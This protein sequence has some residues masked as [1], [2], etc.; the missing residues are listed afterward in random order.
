MFK[1]EKKDSFNKKKKKRPKAKYEDELTQI[2]K[3][4]GRGLSFL[5]DS[6]M[7]VFRCLSLYYFF[8][9]LRELF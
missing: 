2:S 3:V 9:I 8:L 1:F 5:H 7:A 4:A 6:H